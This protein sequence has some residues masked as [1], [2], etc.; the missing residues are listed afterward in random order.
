MSS[1]AVEE[2]TFQ[3]QHIREYPGALAKSQEDA[4]MLHAKSYTPHEVK[5]G[6]CQGELTNIAFHA[7]AFHKEVYEPFFDE[8]Y[9]TLKYKHGLTLSS[10][11]IADQA[12]QGSSARLNDGVLGN[13]PHWFDHSRDILCMVNTFRAQMKRPIAAVGHS[14][15]DPP[16]TLTFTRSYPA[17]LKYTL[18]KPEA[19]PSREEAERA[20]RASPFF[21]TWDERALKR[22]VETAWWEA[23]P[24]EGSERR[25]IKLKTSLG[26]E[27][28]TIGRPNLDHIGEPISDLQR[29]THPDVT[30]DSPLTGPAYNPHTRAAYSDL[31]SLRPPTLFVLGKGS[32][33]CPP[34]ELEHRTSITGKAPGGSG[35]Q[36][37]GRVHS[38]TIAGGHFLPMTNINGTA[39]ETAR[40]LKVR[41]EGWRCC[42][43]AFTKE[44]EST[45][46]AERQRL[47]H[48]LL[49][50]WDGKPWDK[51]RTSTVVTAKL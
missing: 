2:H 32:Q 25:L 7:N 39:E 27:V 48:D 42:E 38:I 17:M 51:G 16:K 10:I 34:N 28:R 14:M 26:S 31:E 19:Y 49:R 33:I 50:K 22:Y 40:W 36:S 12:A 47:D 6:Q 41:I 24:A 37:A 5:S 4:L 11:W 9:R 15:G 46:I 35:G 8:L 43:A 29:Y 44:W 45:T 18:S 3:G 13:D 21:K 23:P 1:L 30:P 20:T